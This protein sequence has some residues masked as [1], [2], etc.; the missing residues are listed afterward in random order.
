[1]G[2]MGQ[3]ALAPS[4]FEFFAVLELQ[5]SNGGSEPR[6]LRIST[7]DGLPFSNPGIEAEHTPYRS[8]GSK[9]GMKVGDIKD[10]SYIL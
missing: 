10:P 9:G 2:L 8:G 7:E 5:I 6:D 3:F 4:S 1:M